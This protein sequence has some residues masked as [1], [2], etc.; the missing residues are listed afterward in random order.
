MNRI[1]E[2][3]YPKGSVNA[4]RIDTDVFFIDENA[5]AQFQGHLDQTIR[6]IEKVQLLDAVLWKRFV[7]QF[8]V[9]SDTADKGWRG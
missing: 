8:R 2:T 9:F 7:E 1:V 3:L 6:Y 4:K 5:K